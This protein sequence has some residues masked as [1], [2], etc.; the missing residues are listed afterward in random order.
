MTASSHYLNQYWL[1][2]SGV[3]WKSP[4]SNFTRD[5]SAINYKDELEN[6][7]I[8]LKS[9]RG[10][11]VNQTMALF[12]QT[13]HM[14]PSLKTKLLPTLCSVAALGFFITNSGTTGS[15]KVHNSCYH[16]EAETKWPSFFQ[17]TFS[18]GFSWLKMYEFRLT[19]HWSLFPG[20]Q[21]TIIQHWF[22]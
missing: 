2:I 20:V 6:S 4:Q 17:T 19:F 3:Q 11:Q 13:S 9:P 1:T 8:S 14:L 16:I 21:L 7:K 22:R 15:G 12:Q 18:N 10:H 5:T